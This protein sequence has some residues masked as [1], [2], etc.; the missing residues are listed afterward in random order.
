MMKAQLISIVAVF[1]VIFFAA[2]AQN[3]RIQA[4]EAL[5]K[6]KGCTD[7]HGPNNKAFG[8][9]FKDMATKYK[10]DTTARSAMIEAVKNGSKGKWTEVSHGVPMPPYAGRLSDTEIRK[11]VDWLVHQ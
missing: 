9:S 8:P 7:C 2:K 3:V 11:L 4:P 10:K 5:A 6:R 1:L